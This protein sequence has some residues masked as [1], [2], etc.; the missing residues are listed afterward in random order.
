MRLIARALLLSA[1]AAALFI[2]SVTA[3]ATPVSY[4][5]TQG[6]SV[7]AGGEWPPSVAQ[8]ASA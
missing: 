4:H 5:S 7:V 1:A 2:P 8:N 3:S 6:V